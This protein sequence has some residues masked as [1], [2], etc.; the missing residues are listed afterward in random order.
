[1][2]NILKS[3]LLSSFLFLSACGGSSSEEQLPIVGN[4]IN[5]VAIGDSTI[6]SLYYDTNKLKDN[7][8]PGSSVTT[9]GSP[10]QC[11]IEGQQNNLN[12]IANSP[13][14]SVIIFLSGIN[15]ARRC[16]I[17]VE[18]FR[19]LVIDLH[20]A[21]CSAGSKFVVITPNPTYTGAENEILTQYAIMERQLGYNL[22]DLRDWIE[23]PSIS[24]T[25]D[26]GVQVAVDGTH[27]TPII[28]EWLSPKLANVIMKAK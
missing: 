6:S 4:S 18:Q 25:F 24:K 19:L 11:A 21:S 17:T 28:Y 15:D 26:Y 12:I 14:G 9:Y 23:N 1:M 13:T 20:N 10:G 22:A 8:P 27:M 2:Q 7:L 3:L 5:V 16:D